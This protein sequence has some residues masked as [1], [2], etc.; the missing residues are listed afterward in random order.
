M[1][2]RIHYWIYVE[3]FKK[4]SL[5]VMPE[6]MILE[7]L[8]HIYWWKGER[9]SYMCNWEDHRLSA[10]FTMAFNKI[11]NSQ[12]NEDR[13]IRRKRKVFNLRISLDFLYWKDVFFIIIEE[14]KK[15]ESS[16]RLESTHMSRVYVPWCTINVLGKFTK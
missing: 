10:E 7:Q 5:Y 14:E 2:N 12:W 1:Q 13:Q 8:T 11:N 3:L 6:S 15:N 16:H 4:K 9:K